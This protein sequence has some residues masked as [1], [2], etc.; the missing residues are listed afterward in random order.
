MSLLTRCPRCRTLFRVTP[1]QLQARGGKVRCGRCMNVFDGF[2]ALAV[3]Q[4]D[5]A[6]EPLRFEAQEA[7]AA[8]E[9]LRFEA[10]ETA[11]ATAPEPPAPE[12][13][14]DNG[15]LDTAPEHPRTCSHGFWRSTSAGRD[16][17]RHGA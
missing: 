9:P 14:P 17:A 6:R 13:T 16:G 12:P 15:V 3:E 5:A 8:P 7:E 11:T 10:Q 2:Q 4:V 1:A